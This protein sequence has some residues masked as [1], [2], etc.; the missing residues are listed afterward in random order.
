M[1]RTPPTDDNVVIEDE[2]LLFEDF[3]SVR[4]ATISIRRDRRDDAPPVRRLSLERGDSVAAIIVDADRQV[5]VLVRQFRYPAARH[6]SPWL[7]ELVAGM[8]PADEEPHEAVVREIAEEVGLLVRRTDPI[9]WFYLSPGGSSERLFLYYFEVT[10]ASR[11]DRADRPTDPEEEIELVEVP[12]GKLRSLLDA[13][14]EIVDAKTIIGLNWL[15]ARAGSD[16][17]VPDQEGTG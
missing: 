7:L 17:T 9:G 6:G 11:I 15:L 12:L 2:R 16:V 14:G 8:V 3:F 1:E 13:D 5:A 4:E 10:G